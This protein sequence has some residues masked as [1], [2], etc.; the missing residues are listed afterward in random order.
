[1]KPVK[2]PLIFPRGQPAQHP[3]STGFPL[4]KNR[5]G[6]ANSAIPQAVALTTFLNPP[7]LPNRRRQL[8]KLQAVVQKWEKAASPRPAMSTDAEYEAF[9]DKA[10][11]DAGDDVNGKGKAVATS[12]SKSA[13]TVTVNTAVPAA[14]QDVEEYYMSDAD[15]PFEPVSLKWPEKTIPSAGG[16]Q[17]YISYSF[18]PHLRSIEHCDHP[19]TVKLSAATK[20]F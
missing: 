6:K 18:A 10:N 5:Q 11:K 17:W 12:D 8:S 15:E 1:M 14:L 4:A 13:G 3:A 2:R 16:Y 19:H 9:L 7:L 20:I